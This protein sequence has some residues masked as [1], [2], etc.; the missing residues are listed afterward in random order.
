[1]KHALYSYLEYL[2]F[3]NTLYLASYSYISYLS[4]QRLLQLSFM[5]CEVDPLPIL[6]S[7][8]PL[9]PPSSANLSTRLKAL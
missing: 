4:F 7:I 6:P 8:L 9:L 2:Q 5:H 3:P 1:M